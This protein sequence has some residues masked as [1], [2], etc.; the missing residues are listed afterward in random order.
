[1]KLI[2]TLCFSLFLGAVSFSQ[3]IDQR[4][5]SKYTSI[6]LNEMLES[7][8]EDYALLNYALDN[9]IYFS[10]GTGEKANQ[11][12]TISMPAEGA[13]FIDLGLEIQDQNQYF[14]IAGDDRLLVVKSR[15]VLNYEMQKKYEKVY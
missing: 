8:P 13:N 2:T 4:L 5:L 6:E 15:I 11:L 10:K 1:M 9:A 14:Q 7:A 12:Q 3:E